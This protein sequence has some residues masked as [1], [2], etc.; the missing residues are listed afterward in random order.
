MIQL[1]IRNSTRQ[2]KSKRKEWLRFF[3]RPNVIR[4]GVKMHIVLTDVIVLKKRLMSCVKYLKL[5]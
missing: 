5:V 1:I 3:C 2:V 4:K